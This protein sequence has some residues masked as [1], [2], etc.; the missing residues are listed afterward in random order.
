MVKSSKAKRR[1]RRNNRAD[2]DLSVVYREPRMRIH[3]FSRLVN[4]GTIAQGAL[5][6]G[7]GYAVLLQNLPNYTEFT[8]LFNQYRIMQVDVEYVLQTQLISGAFPRLSYCV[9]YNDNT[10][11][12]SEDQ[13]L[14]YENASV[15]N[16]SQMKTVFKRSYVPR[17]ALPAYQGAFTAYTTSPPGTWVDCDNPG[18]LHYGWKHW[19]SNYNSTST[20]TV[21]VKLYFRLHFECRGER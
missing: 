7:F 2:K 11:P 13:I 6:T 20:P 14:Q 17:I 8:A 16:F 21:Q 15:C 12:T 5:D 10:N 18:V 19:L 9:D 1:S 3:R 4:Y